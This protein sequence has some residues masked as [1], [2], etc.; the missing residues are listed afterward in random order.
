MVAEVNDTTSIETI[1]KQS[2]QSAPYEK[3]TETCLELLLNSRL[4][5]KLQQ[6]STKEF[7]LY[8][9]RIFTESVLG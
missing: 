4:R 9:Q 8:P 7:K 5:S 3:L 2:I 1:F 6:E